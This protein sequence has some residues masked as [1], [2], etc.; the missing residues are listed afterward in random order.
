MDKI[1]DNYLDNDDNIKSNITTSQVGSNDD[2][3]S[4][5]AFYY[6]HFYLNS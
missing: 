2:K 3:V 1:I 6:K 4:N 5:F